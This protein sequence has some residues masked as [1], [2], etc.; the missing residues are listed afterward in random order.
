MTFVYLALAMGLIVGYGVAF[1]VYSNNPARKALEEALALKQRELSDYQNKVI[2][3]FQKTS[4]LVEALHAHHSTILDHL[5]EGAKNLRPHTVVESMGA[6]PKDYWITNDPT[7]VA[8]A[9]D[10]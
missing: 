4:E 9:R 8:A 10:S 6:Q 1:I 7:N 2:A 3:H 5:C